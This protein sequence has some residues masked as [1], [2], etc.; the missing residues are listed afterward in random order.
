MCHISLPLSHLYLSPSREDKKRHSNRPSQLECFCVPA[1][2]PQPVRSVHSQRAGVQGRLFKKLALD[3]TTQSPSNRAPPR[4]HPLPS[5][6]AKID[7]IRLRRSIG[8]VTT[9]SAFYCPCSQHSG[10]E[11]SCLSPEKKE[12]RTSHELRRVHNVR[13]EFNSGE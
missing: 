13:L 10:F 12:K 11:L 9:F 1:S 8:R 6:E 3:G 2:H 4:R 7:P 5:H